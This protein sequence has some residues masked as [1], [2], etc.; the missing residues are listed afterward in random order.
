MTSPH[1]SLSLYASLYHQTL[2]LMQLKQTIEDELQRLAVEMEKL[3]EVLPDE[4]QTA[5]IEEA[6]LF[7]NVY[8][9]QMWMQMQPQ[10]MTPTELRA[11]HAHLYAQLQALLFLL[12]PSKEYGPQRM[13]LD[14]PTYWP[15]KVA[16]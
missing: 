11:L 3:L 13:R 15:S 8:D 9:A 12:P 6:K 4:E 1:V 10:F 5:L 16:N 14:R 7:A 2:A